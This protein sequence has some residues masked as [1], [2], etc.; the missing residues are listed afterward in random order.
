VSCFEFVTRSVFVSSFSRFFLFFFFLFAREVLGG[1]TE[2]GGA[3]LSF[4]RFFS[5]SRYLVRSAGVS[6]VSPLDFSRLWGLT[7][8]VR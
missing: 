1:F 8:L 4:F 7:T 3:N 5:L 6:A 2:G